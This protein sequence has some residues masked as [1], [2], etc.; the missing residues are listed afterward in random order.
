MLVVFTCLSAAKR[1][2][3]CCFWRGGKSKK[4]KSMRRK[5]ASISCDTYKEP[6]FDF[7]QDRSVRTRCAVNI[8]DSL[9]GKK[10]KTNH[11]HIIVVLLVVTML[12]LAESPGKGATLIGHWTFDEGT[13]NTA[14][15]SSGN[16][17]NGTITNAV[18]TNGRIGSNALYFNGVDANVEVPNND[19][20][21]P[22]TIGISLWFKS[23]SIGFVDA[24]DK[25]HGGGSSPYFA[26]YAIQF[27]YSYSGT[28][29]AGV[30]G[31]GSGDASGF[32]TVNTNKYLG[33]NNWHHMVVNLGQEGC[34]IYVDAVLEN[35]IS[36]QGPLVQN[37]SNLY[38]GKHRTVGRYFNGW[39]DDVRLYNGALS[40]SE[41][42]DLFG[43]GSSP[44][45]GPSWCDGAD[46]NKDGRVDFEDFAI[47]AIHW[48]EGVNP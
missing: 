5:N 6:S 8:I 23:E 39:L 1:Y 19:I 17:L 44:C 14:F 37:D 33:D 38:F 22:Q 15:D 40:E 29:G 18:Y 27:D 4:E 12:V 47:V 25:G 9:N 34:Q 41:V 46:I 35:S 32:C 11:R 24:L 45:T 28:G 10:V 36:S 21:V 30:Y 42:R 43:S 31:Y 16:G 13:G 26:G 20:L 2:N 7:A 48:L 3:F